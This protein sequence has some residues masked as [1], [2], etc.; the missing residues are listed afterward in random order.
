MAFNQFPYS[1]FHE[2]N[3]DWVVDEIKRL[4]RSFE[5]LKQSSET[6][7]NDLDNATADI[8]KWISSFDT[9]YIEKVVREY[10]ATMIFVEISEAGYMIY[11]IPDNWDNMSFNTTGL[12]VVL[13]QM[14]Q[15]GHLVINY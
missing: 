8:E 15:Y 14:P 1:N 5:D 6:H 3:L 10:L 12:D 13:Q 4:Q 2:L 11:H 9:A 7:F